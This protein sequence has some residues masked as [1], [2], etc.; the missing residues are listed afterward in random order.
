MQ[1]H[2]APATYAYIY[3]HTRTLRTCKI[4]TNRDET[5]NFK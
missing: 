5:Q 2:Y 4:N 1:T 3:T